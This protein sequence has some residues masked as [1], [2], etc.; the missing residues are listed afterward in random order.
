MFLMCYRYDKSTIQKNSKTVLTSDH[1]SVSLVMEIAQQVKALGSDYCEL[2]ERDVCS[3]LSL[4]Q[5]LH[6]L[7]VNYQLHSILAAVHQIRESFLST[8]ESVSLS[9]A[10]KNLY[11]CLHVT[12]CS[13][14]SKNLKTNC[15]DIQSLSGNI[16][17]VLEDSVCSLNTGWYLLI[18]ECLLV[19]LKQQTMIP[20]EKVTL[21]E[22]VLD[23][24]QKVTRFLITSRDDNKLQYEE[25]SKDKNEKLAVMIS[26]KLIIIL[27]MEL[28]LGVSLV[29]IIKGNTCVKHP[30]P[31]FV[32]RKY[33]YK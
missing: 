11:D 25:D 31:L 9:H 19:I 18:C 4:F 24:T 7:I 22:E 20:P 17:A 13:T 14:K 8:F 30:T 29:N 21:W 32:E 12:M 2:T 28:E 5:Y 26:T 1:L 15:S 23:Y 27:R 33:V 16:V 10:M 6:Q 3:S